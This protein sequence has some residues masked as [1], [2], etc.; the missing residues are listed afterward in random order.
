MRNIFTTTLRLNLNDEEDRR[1]WVY[2]QSMDKQKY[3]SYREAIVTAVNDYFSRQEQAQQ[4]QAFLDRVM[5]T[6]EKSLQNFPVSAAPPAFASEPDES[7]L[8]AD[9]AFADSF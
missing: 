2:L 7:S 8:D 9:L 5:A 3:R 4:E 1:A 6:I